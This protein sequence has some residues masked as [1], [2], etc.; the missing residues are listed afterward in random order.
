MGNKERAVPTIRSRDL[1]TRVTRIPAKFRRVRLKS[2]TRASG[3]S[4]RDET[5][6]VLIL[7]LA[8]ILAIGLVVGTLAD[9]AS[10]SLRNTSQFQSASELHYAL[11]SATNTAIESIRY[12]P[13]PSNPTIA[14]NNGQATPIG[15]CWTPLSGSASTLTVDGYSVA[16]WCTTTIDL[17]Q[18]TTRV[19]SFFTCL[20]TV[21]AAQCAS[22]PLLAA[23]VTYDD[24]PTGGGVTLTEQC[25][26]ENGACGFGQTLDYWT[27]N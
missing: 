5:G 20:S 2:E 27:W 6:A 1:I 18:N 13:L 21:T 4:D 8:F 11:S 22:A 9:W 14:E 12:S 3:G 17:A 23:Q 16:V 15:E 19:V 7:A 24:Y 10:N 25:N 26:L